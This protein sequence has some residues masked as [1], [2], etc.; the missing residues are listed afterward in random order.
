MNLTSRGGRY[1]APVNESP[2]QR[3]DRAKDFPETGA[4]AQS[5]KDGVAHRWLE[6]KKPALA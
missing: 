5:S 6:K 1:D 2:T 4:P 3:K